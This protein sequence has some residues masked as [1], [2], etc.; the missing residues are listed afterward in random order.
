MVA[1][2]ADLLLLELLPGETATAPTE[3]LMF[4]RGVTSTTKGPVVY[5]TDAAVTVLQ[6]YESRGLDLLP[7]DCA[8]GMLQSGGGPEQHKALGW[9]RPDCREDGLYAADVQWTAEGKR[10]VEAREFRFVSPAVML[11]YESGRVQEVINLALTNIPATN[12]Q[13]PLVAERDIMKEQLIT[14]LS[15]S[16]DVDE[17]AITERIGALLE[18]EKASVTALAAVAELTSE[19][20]TLRAQLS[21]IEAEKAAAMRASECDRLG[22]QGAARDYAM[23]LDANGFAAFGKLVESRVS[24]L[25]RPIEAPAS[26]AAPH[27]TITPEQK[28]IAALLNIDP[29]VFSTA[30][31]EGK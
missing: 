12:N 31:K 20:E 1:D 16:A 4:G 18:A 26:D 5:D 30:G 11:D 25:S 10:M 13:K 2:N 14:A 21:S 9:F 24:L 23:A 8:H 27:V 15:L 17:A 28:R 6:A 29:A 3:I 7:I 19:V 22:L